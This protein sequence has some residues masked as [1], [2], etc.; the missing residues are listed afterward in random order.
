MAVRRRRWSHPVVWVVPVMVLLVLIGRPLNDVYFV[1][2]VDQDP[3]PDAYEWQRTTLIFRY[4][5]GLLCGQL[6]AL[7]AGAALAVRY[8]QAVALAYAVPLGALLAAAGFVLGA[9]LGPVGGLDLF[10]FGPQIDIDYDPLEDPVVVRVLVRELAAYPLFAAFGVGL[11]VLLG[12]RHAG[13]RRVLWCL[14]LVPPWIVATVAGLAQT[15][16]GDLPHWLYWAVPPIGAAAAVAQAG[17]PAD[18]GAGSGSGLDWGREASLALLVGVAAYAVCLNLLV[19]RIENRRAR[20]RAAAAA[21][22]L[23]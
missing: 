8:R 5:S 12:G 1:T 4:T 7:V 14:L 20:R 17:L 11:G 22:A 10:G 19:H 6:L 16:R 23:R 2:F 3:D 18:A 9:V 21:D 15:Y 13:R